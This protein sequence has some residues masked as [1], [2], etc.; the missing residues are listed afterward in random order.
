MFSFKISQ[1]GARR[2]LR[3]DLEE[4]VRSTPSQRRHMLKPIQQAK[5]MGAKT[6]NE[7]GN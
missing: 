2:G 4:V 3:V 6:R 1:D 5:D 7:I